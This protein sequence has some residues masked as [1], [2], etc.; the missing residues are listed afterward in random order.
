MNRLILYQGNTF[1]NECT[2]SDSDG[3]VVDLTGLTVSMTI[4]NESTEVKQVNNTTHTSPALGITTFTI[5]KT[6]TANFPATLLIYEVEIT[7]TD[8][9]KFTAIRDV[10]EVISDLA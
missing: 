9:S 8:G 2:I 6:E 1:V 7:Y 4:Y 3:N 5:S 10:L